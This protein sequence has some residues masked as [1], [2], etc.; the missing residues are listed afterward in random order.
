MRHFSMVQRA[1]DLATEAVMAVHADLAAR[2]KLRW[3]SADIPQAAEQPYVLLAAFKL[4][5]EFDRQVAPTDVVM[6]E[7]ALARMIAL[8]TSGER[9]PAQYF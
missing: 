1:P 2:G 9:T 7:K 3:S 6:A 5:P 8:P 4:G